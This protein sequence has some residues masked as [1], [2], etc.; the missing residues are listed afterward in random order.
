MLSQSLTVFAQALNLGYGLAAW[1]MLI[2]FGLADFASFWLVVLLVGSF[3]QQFDLGLQTILGRNF[4]YAASGAGSLEAIGISS[5]QRNSG[6]DAT[7]NVSTPLYSNL[8]FTSNFLYGRLSIIMSAVAIPLG[9]LYLL[10]ARSS[11][12]SGDVIACWLL[13]A[14][15]FL[16]FFRYSHHSAAIFGAGNI[17][18]WNIVFIINRLIFLFALLI[19]LALD[20]GLLSIGFAS[21]ISAAVARVV[22]WEIVKKISFLDLKTG[23][24]ELTSNNLT[25]VFLYSIKRVAA[26]N[27]SAFITYKSSGLI[28]S[29]YFGH[30]SASEFNL[31]VA[32][33]SAIN[34]VALALVNIKIPDAGG[35]LVSERYADFSSL[36]RKVSAQVFI[37][38]FSILF[39]LTVLLTSAHIYGYFLLDISPLFLVLL[40]L[41]YGLDLNHAFSCAIITMENR[42]PYVASSVLSSLAILVF[43]FLA[44]PFFG[45]A[46]VFLPQLVVQLAYNNWKWP[47][48]MR[49]RFLVA[50]EA[51]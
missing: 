48:Y 3:L 42:Y 6:A 16:I 38:Y 13:W 18:A 45:I 29:A 31:V 17:R 46:A 50:Y 25:E 51:R 30:D 43:N 41:M 24:A 7:I 8:F 32:I 12:S 20:F 9:L 37:L 11:I 36:V 14:L 21:I 19:F 5:R 35:F 33:L 23:R 39:L 10:Q 1:A 26:L 34:S 28:L 27:F 22:S 2:Y 40:V 44:I 4:V 15:G 49:D 47:I